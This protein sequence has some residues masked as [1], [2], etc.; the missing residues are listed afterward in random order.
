MSFE[1]RAVSKAY[2]GSAVLKG[3]SITLKTGESVAIL[4]RSGSGKSTLLRLLAG[5]E[6]PT[7]GQVLVH[8]AM[9][10]ESGKIFL[11]PHRRG[12]SMVFQD[13]ALWPNLTVVGNVLLGLSGLP[14]SRAQRKVHALEALA[15]CAIEHLGSRK[16]SQ[17]SG[18]EQQRVA[19]ARAVARR[20]TFLLLDEPFSGLDPVTKAQVVEEISRLTRTEGITVILV[21]HEPL[22]ALALCGKGIV[23]E[24]GCIVEAGPW[25]ELLRTPRSRLLEVFKE[26]LG[27][28]PQ[29][30]QMDS[31]PK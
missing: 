8:G 6:A 10:S 30:A 12:V 28:V 5:L 15:L 19:L 20:P 4:G 13:L 21:T 18:G 29:G 7:K 26:R 3:L 1:L 27:T 11:Q 16:L 31:S 25:V 17:I 23:L 22:D 24:D 9:A 14:L 2:D